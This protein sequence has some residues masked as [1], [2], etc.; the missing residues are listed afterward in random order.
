LT[1][2]TG[3]GYP[4][5]VSV[6]PGCTVACRAFRAARGL[7]SS[8]GYFSWEGFR[9]QAIGFGL[10]HIHCHIIRVICVLSVGA[11]SFN[12][13]I[14]FYAIGQVPCQ[15]KNEEEATEAH[16]CLGQDGFLKLSPSEETK[17]QVTLLKCFIATLEYIILLFT[18]YV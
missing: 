7:V 9:L 13:I 2:F 11:V 15:P 6:A 18:L 10:S 1:T 14:L 12:D 16:G 8:A 17:C 3:G 5:A 4:G